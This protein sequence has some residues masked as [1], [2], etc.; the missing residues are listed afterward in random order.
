PGDTVVRTAE[1]ELVVVGSL[2]VRATRWLVPYADA[3][4]R[5]GGP[6]GLIRLDD[7]AATL[8]VLQAGHELPGE[9][10]ASLGEAIADLAG[11]VAR[12]VVRP[13]LDV[14][15]GDLAAVGCR[16]IT[17]LSSA[18]EGAIVDAYQRIKSLVEA[19]RASGG[20]PPALA[21]AVLGA[22][23]RRAERMQQQLSRTT[24]TFLEVELPLAACVQRM[25][26]GVEATERLTFSGEPKPPL[27]SV[28]RWI[29]DATAAA[30]P[31]PTTVME[32]PTDELQAVGGS[33]FPDE[34]RAEPEPSDA[35]RLVPKPG[36]RV[37][38]KEPAPAAEPD[39]EGVP[40]PLASYIEGVT[41]LDV[42]CPGHERLELGI[43]PAGRLQVIARQER[44][45]E[46]HVVEAWARAH[47]ELIG[48]A[49]PGHWIDP[50]AGTVCHVFTDEPAAL[51]DLHGSALRLHV[52]APVFVDGKQGWYAAPLN[53][54]VR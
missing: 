30:E 17:I 39:D 15:P 14:T 11:H 45:R 21:L 31:V 27:R 28:L 10:W 36:A 43:D 49:C 42:R 26:S 13:A 1:I 7:E 23:R 12:W 51:A 8:Q 33:E 25:E 50:A 18:N 22:E 44:L 53:A 38:P 3:G 40:V 16:R 34:P 47:R 5:D 48:K 54:T 2:P 20:G 52:L 6:T 4:G 37:E 41:P 24:K 29:R 35:V 46:L 32:A 19:A 9:R